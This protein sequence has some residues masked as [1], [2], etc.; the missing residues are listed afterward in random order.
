TRRSTRPVDGPT[1]GRGLRPDANQST[2]SRAVGT[3]NFPPRLPL[4]PRAPCREVARILLLPAP[5]PLLGWRPLPCRASDSRAPRG[6]A[7][8]SSLSG[9][10]P[11]GGGA[12]GRCWQGKGCTPPASRLC[13]SALGACVARP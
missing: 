1:G 11:C 6:L 9:Q 2:T 5:A 3:P 13:A 10:S 7:C 12:A 8:A 4:P